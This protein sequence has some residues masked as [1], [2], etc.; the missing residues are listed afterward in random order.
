MSSLS[1]AISRASDKF[2]HLTIRRRLAA[3]VLA[4]AQ[5]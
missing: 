1:H 2:K 3:L 5:V 4:L